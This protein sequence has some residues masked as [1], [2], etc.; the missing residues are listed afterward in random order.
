MATH[1]IEAVNFS[2]MAF[3]TQ[4]GEHTVILDASP[5]VGGQ[6]LGPSPKIQLL[7]AMAGCTGIDVVGMLNKMRVDF[8]DFSI[9]V[10][11]QLNDDHP[12]VYHTIFVNYKIKVADADREKMEKAV[13][14]SK[15]KYCGVSIMMGKAA[16]IESQITYLS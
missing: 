8:S 7:N 13:K 11:G 6:G 15:E 16:R 10:T 14:L 12:K 9:E 1:H 3:R 4:M 2:G 5:E